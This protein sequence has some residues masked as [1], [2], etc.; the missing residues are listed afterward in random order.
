MP[1][2]PR[3]ASAQPTASFSELLPPPADTGKPRL[4]IPPP[5]PP[6]E[7]L[8]PCPGGLSCRLHLL[9]EIR[10]DGAIELEATTFTW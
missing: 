7:E 8:L 2:V 6:Q 10:K 9:G 1:L 4:F 5:L 3:P